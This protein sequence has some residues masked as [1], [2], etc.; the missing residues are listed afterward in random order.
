MKLTQESFTL[1]DEEYRL[2]IG[3]KTPY[4]ISEKGKLI[5]K[6]GKIY[7]PFMQKQSFG[8]KGKLCY[9]LQKENGKRT[10]VYAHSLVAKHFIES[11]KVYNNKKIIDSKKVVFL[12]GD[13][14][15][16][17]P[18]NMSFAGKK[19]TRLKIKHITI[20]ATNKEDCIERILSSETEENKHRIKKDNRLVID[21]L[22]GNTEAIN[23][24]F[25][26]YYKENAHFLAMY[27]AKSGGGGKRVRGQ[28]REHE[29]QVQD[30]MQ[31]G[32]LKVI[33]ALNRFKYS[34]G[35]FRKWSQ[36]VIFNEFVKDQRLIKYQMKQ[37]KFEYVDKFFD[38]DD[39]WNSL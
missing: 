11:Y 33:E 3:Y 2:I 21:F 10:T 19:R 39:A 34:G 28:M 30:F 6:N 29:K 37:S 14:T 13:S 20:H 36:K 4:F 8:Y 24:L 18:S 15:N 7:K 35:S 17:L 32:L 31:E 22:N 1:N 23:I 5:N 26:H 25:K 27:M 12:D 38:Y 16:I 9:T